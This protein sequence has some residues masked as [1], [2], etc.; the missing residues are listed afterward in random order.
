VS[1]KLLDGSGLARRI[2]EGLPHHPRLRLAIIRGAEDEAS[3]Q[4]RRAKLKACREA[5]IET[6]VLEIVK[7]EEAARDREVDAI[8]VE[9]P[10]P[11]GI[12]ESAVLAAL[13]PAK[14]AEG[15][16]PVNFGRLMMARRWEDLAGLPLPCTASAVIQI[17]LGNDIPIDGREAVVVG[18]S[19]IVGKPAAQMLSLLGA[20]VTLCHSRTRD[21]ASHVRRADILV[22]AAGSPGLVRGEWIKPGAAVIDA[23][24]GTGDVEFE[25][26]RRRAGFITPVPG[27]VGPVTTASL[28]LNVVSLARR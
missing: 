21:L 5:G 14:D 4:Y 15:V 27:G 13:P 7:L 3:A 22:A 18:R 12:K 2:T 6:V 25:P 28:L 8:I 16:S 19:N 10:L 24:A 1:A 26:A 17:L 23:A 20:T 9:L 11:P